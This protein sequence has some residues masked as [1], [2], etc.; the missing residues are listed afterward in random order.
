MR[1]SEGRKQGAGRPITKRSKREKKTH[2]EPEGETDVRG[3][4]SLAKLGTSLRGWRRKI[5]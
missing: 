4:G 3:E 1:K 2:V 5:I